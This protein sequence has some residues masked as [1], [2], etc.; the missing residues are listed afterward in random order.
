MLVVLLVMVLLVVGC[1]V[2]VVDTDEVK[3]GDK[4]VEVDGEVADK[5]FDEVVETIELVGT[6][7]VVRIVK[8]VGTREVDSINGRDIIDGVVNTVDVSDTDDE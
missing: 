7:K 6:V 3:V 8:V 4:E 2:E 5:V 1:T